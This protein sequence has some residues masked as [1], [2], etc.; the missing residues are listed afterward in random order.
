MPDKEFIFGMHPVLE[1]I[2]SGKEME[3]VLIQRE[4]KSQ[5]LPKLRELIRARNIPFQYV[6]KEKL[7]RITRKNHQGIIAFP[8]PIVYHSLEQLLPTIYEKGEV[9][10]FLLLDRVTDVGNFGAIVRTAECNGVHTIVV[11][12]RGSALISAQAVKT[13]AGAIYKLPV[14]REDNLKQTI[15]YLKDS[16]LKVIACTE[17]AEDNCNQADLSGPCA[18]IMG[19]KETGI[20]DEYLKKANVLVKIPMFGEIGSLNVSV[21]TGIILYEVQR[22]R[23]LGE[24]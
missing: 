14:C 18:I 4:M 22:Q 13:S 9:P 19:S 1:A 2:D 15:Q 17:K 20:S 23:G 16:G 6:P 7:N 12:S 24:L 11:P 3:K 5:M 10:F 21:A 8:S